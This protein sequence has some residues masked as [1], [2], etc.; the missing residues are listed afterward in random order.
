MEQVTRRV[1]LALA[2]PTVL[3]ALGGCRTAATSA[4]GEMN[5][6][7]LEFVT[8][9][10]NIITFDREEASLAPAYAQTPEV[11]Q[12]A[13]KLLYDAKTFAAKLYPIIKAHGIELPTEL[14]SDLRIRLLHIRLNRGLD[15]DRSFIDDQ[16]AS[17]QEA[18]DRQEMLMGTPGQNPQLVALLKEGTEVLRQNL[19]AL[20]AIQRELPPPAT[21]TGPF[22]L[23]PPPFVR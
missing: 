3:L 16:I 10:Y 4:S 7:D 11:K 1:V 17:H 21:P 12:I 22:G 15:F 19:A 2:M 18:L 8:Q 13:V 6:A 9:A 5:S 14:R 23:P 20:R